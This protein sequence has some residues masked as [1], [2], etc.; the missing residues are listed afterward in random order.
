[1]TA[2]RAAQLPAFERPVPGTPP[3][4]RRAALTRRLGGAATALLLAAAASGCVTV[5]GATALV[6][7]A[8]RSAATAALARFVTVS[9]AAN[10]A[11][12]PKLN[13]TVETG[14]FGALD[15]ANLTVERAAAPAGDP[16]Y[17]KLVLHDTHVLIPRLRGW[18]KW[19]VVD[20][21]QNRDDARWLMVFTHDSAAQPWRVSYLVPCARTQ[22]PR[23]VTDS[24]GRAVPV[25][26]GAAGL[27][28][29]P[30]LLGARY[31]AYLQ[32]GDRGSGLFADGPY[33]SQERAARRTGHPQ[34]S[35]TV[36]EF[37]DEAG[38]PARYG[39]VAL[40][41]AGGGAL[42]FFTTQ[43]QVRRTV[44]EGPVPVDAR[45]K[46]LLT[47]TAR[48]SVTEYDIAEQAAVVPAHGE[49][50]FVDQLSGEV[51]AHGS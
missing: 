11:L 36:T 4:P 38:D 35:G 21:G 22:A 48:T 40:R 25:P 29:A 51:D 32:H 20:T 47:G 44:A 28:V 37:A 41:L 18:P 31:A 10:L 24:A 1:M 34:D 5:H 15:D 49:V 42:V 14:G 3:R 9:N 23:F 8:T 13:G 17:H 26:G 27:A 45:T 43:S 2:S 46:A 7:T 39:T 12:D 19:F 16:G 6:P 33:T 30:A 50:T